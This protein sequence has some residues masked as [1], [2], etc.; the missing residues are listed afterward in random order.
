VLF[1]HGIGALQ[2]AYYDGWLEQLAQK[3]FTVVFPQYQLYTSLWTQYPQYAQAAWVDALSRMSANTTGQFVI[4]QKDSA[5]KYRTATIG[6]SVG[7]FLAATMAGLATVSGSPMPVPLA[8]MI[9]SPSPGNTPFARFG[10]LPSTT[11]LIMVV[12]EDDTTVC[13][14]GVDYLWPKMSQIT[15][16][17][18]LV[19]TTDTYGAPELIA[20]HAFPTAYQDPLGVQT[21]SQDFYGTFKLSVSL[22]SCA[23]NGTNC[24]IAF[25]NGSQEQVD[26]GLWS[27]GKPINDWRWYSDPS[28]AVL[29]CKDSAKF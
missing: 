10:N 16:K 12:G 20:D 29:N 21:N 28:K 22:L 7:G 17:N 27:D 2:P 3:G 15:Q 4:P 5:G 1:L 14:S 25:G 9:V 6:H 26:Q 8:L 18:F 23:F 11:K 19:A 24:N 13:T